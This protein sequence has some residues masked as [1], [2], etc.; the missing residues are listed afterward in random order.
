MAQWYFGE[1][2][3]NQDTRGGEAGPDLDNLPGAWCLL[4][5]ALPTGLGLL[6]SREHHYSVITPVY[7][8]NLNLSDYVAFYQSLEVQSIY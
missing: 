3:N 1:N 4:S 2:I 5:V 6:I 8:W 7:H